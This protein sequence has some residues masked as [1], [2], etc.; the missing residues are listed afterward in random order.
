M[1][2]PAVFRSL[3]LSILTWLLLPVS[4]KGAAQELP[5][6]FQ[7]V[8][9]DVEGLQREA[10]VYAPASAKEKPAPLVF[11]W[12]GHGGTMRSAAKGFP[13]WRLWPEAISVY[14]QGLK[15]PGRLT[16]PE[17]KKPGWQGRIGDQGDRD[18]NFFDAL[19]ARVKQDYRVDPS[20]VYCTGHSNG[21]GF[22]YLLWGARGDTFA[23]VA[24]SAAAARAMNDDMAKLK[25]KPAMHSAG[26]KDPLV[27]F[28]WQQA[29]MNAVR[30]LNGCEAEGKA[31]DKQCLIYES[32]TGTPFVSFI[33]PGG[34][35]LPPEE[36]ALIVRF[37]QEVGKGRESK[38][39]E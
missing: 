12:H 7:F 22:T 1:K 24:P 32:K 9:L 16:D 19:L 39:G 37:F 6:G 14:A 17:G 3:C 15:T 27:K 35:G 20:R 4:G 36:P 11:V 13:F 28:E 26:M 8:R 10:V 2:T 21:G 5:P 25:P 31:W 23:A 33:H 38:K 30:K 18:L 34:H 29:A